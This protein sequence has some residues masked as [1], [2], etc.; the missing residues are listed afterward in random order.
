MG[1]FLG[2]FGFSGKRKRRK[3]A[4]KIQPGDQGIGSYEPL[5]SYVPVNLD[6]TGN[7]RSSDSK[8]SCR[9]KERS[10]NKIRKKVSFNLNVQTYEPI[11]SD[12]AATGFGETDEEGGRKEETGEENLI[13]SKIRSYPSNHRY[14][15]FIDS[16]DEED[17]IA[18][19]DNE[20][21]ED[22]DDDWY[23]DAS[24]KELNQEEE[25]PGNEASFKWFTEDKNANL[26]PLSASTDEELRTFGADA[27]ERSEYA[28]SVLKPVENLTQWKAMKA[29]AAPPKHQKKENTAVEQASMKQLNSNSKSNLQASSLNSESNYTPLKPL[30]PEINVAASLSNWITAPQ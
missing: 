15:N 5:D 3:P 11:C 6:I 4:N 14:R 27:R 22:D 12:E 13:E 26:K 8:I 23:C 10:C 17:D 24:D 7:P 25:L 20:S 30:L 9:P 28:H 18:Y 21:E 16:Y 1:C 29:S 19:L 2:C